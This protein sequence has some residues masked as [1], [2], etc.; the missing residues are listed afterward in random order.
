MYAWKTMLAAVKCSLALAL[1]ALSLPAHA[2][3]ACYIESLGTNIEWTV[4][5]QFH[6]AWSNPLYCWANGAE[7]IYIQQHFSGVR[8]HV[9]SNA[10]GQQLVVWMGDDAD[11]IVNNL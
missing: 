11:F 1:F 3:L 7:L 8:M 9:G 5:N 6:G 10:A 4:G 2:V